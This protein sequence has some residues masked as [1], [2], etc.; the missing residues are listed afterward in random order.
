MRRLNVNEKS[1]LWNITR[2]QKKKEKRKFL[3]LYFC[4]KKV[5]LKY[6]YGWNRYTMMFMGLWPR[7]RSLSQPSNYIVLAPVLAM[8]CFICVPQSANLPYIW[9]DFNLVVENLSVGN[10]TITISLLKTIIFWSKGG[11]KYIN[12]HIEIL[13][14]FLSV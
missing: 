1:V 11:R 9:H 4:L 14:H 2:Y 3:S 6:A 13:V 10:V 5:D 7:H 12:F 8:L